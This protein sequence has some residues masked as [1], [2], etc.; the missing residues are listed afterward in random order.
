MAHEIEDNNAMFVGSPAWHGLGTVLPEAPSIADAIKL[1]GLDWN[2]RMETLSTP[3]GKLAPM[4][5]TV[6]ESD[7]S[8]LG[9]VGV[10]YT[11]LQNTKAF[12][13]F[14]PLVDA[15]LVKLE[16]AGCLRQGQRIWVL[17]KTSVDPVEIV[18]GDPVMSYILLSN[19]H[20]GKLACRAGFTGIR[21]VCANTMA[22]A[23]R[24][25]ASK[26]LRVRHHSK[27]EDTLKGIREV[28]NV[29]AQDF[30]ATAEQ[31]RNLAARQINAADFKKFVKRVF[32]LKDETPAD[33]ASSPVIEVVETEDKDRKGETLCNRI[34]PLF[35]KGRGNNLPGVAGTYWAAY[36]AV[37]EYLTHERGRTQDTRLDSLWYGQAAAFNQKAL[38]TALDMANI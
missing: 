36:N 27:I 3:D 22:A 9:V 14:Q 30:Q 12:E 6:R 25:R 10:D 34:V 13:W 5:A 11:V 33:V 4:R 21:V 26:L 37:S 2:V 23:H 18:P 17:A 29:A 20:D 8:I 24:D 16:S 1:A 28:M 7:N 38:N 31:Y 19:G 32:S 15:G 35:E